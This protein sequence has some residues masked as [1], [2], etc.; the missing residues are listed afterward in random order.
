MRKKTQVKLMLVGVLLSTQVSAVL[1]NQRTFI[2]Y[3]G[4]LA[5]IAGDI[6]DKDV[7][8]ELRAQS[9]SRPW[10]AVGEIRTGQSQL[11]TRPPNKCTGTWLGEQGRW[12]FILTA[13]HCLPDEAKSRTVAA[14]NAAFWGSAGTLLASGS[15]TSYIPQE[16]IDNYAAIDDQGRPIRDRFDVAIIRLPRY[17]TPVDASGLSLDPPV[18]NDSPLAD[19][20]KAFIFVG[21]GQW[22]VGNDAQ[23]AYAPR[24]G[25]I[26][27]Y[28]RSVAIAK[29]GRL[30]NAYDPMGWL[31]MEG[32]PAPSGSPNTRWAGSAPGDSG[33]A[34]WQFERGVPTIVGVNSTSFTAAPAFNHI[35]WI[36]SIF[37]GV[38]LLS[39]VQP[40]GCLVL[41]QDTPG[42]ARRR[43]CITAS[44]HA[45]GRLPD[46][47]RGKKV[48]VQADS[49]V[50]VFLSD[51]D[52]LTFH[53]LVGFYGTVL[54]P[55]L[56]SAKLSN[57]G[58][59]DLSRPRSMWVGH[60][61]G[62]PLGCIVSL[63]TAEKFCRPTDEPYKQHL[64]P[65][66]IRGQDVFVQADPGSTVML[67][68]AA[69]QDASFSG[70]TD[71]TALLGPD[72][73]GDFTRPTW[74]KVAVP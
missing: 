11:V 69:G 70:T 68:N 20:A 30:L 6:R 41:L 27:L 13:A 55:A 4:N 44:A 46:W 42:G 38:K 53:R 62:K 31:T 14:M 15:G 61:V 64:V 57:G 47:I 66:W 60:A 19:H 63:V 49:G 56:R 39:Q 67:R 35:N 51:M 24:S 1:V 21:H 73:V 54:N 9:Y 32:V 71:G 2:S 33:S 3:G 59:L 22:G 72:G 5:H 43:Y 50:T 10:L 12:T 52:D 45:G 7:L 34:W 28:G 23:G 26:R 48:E 8:G 58:Y 37:P 40:Q 16:R 36:K 18:V 25:P 17:Q 65:S 74:M 29:S